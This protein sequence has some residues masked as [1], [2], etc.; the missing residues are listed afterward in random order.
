MG[1]SKRAMQ[2]KAPRG[3]AVEWVRPVKERCRAAAI[4][5]QHFVVVRILRARVRPHPIVTVRRPMARPAVPSCHGDYRRD[6]TE[7]GTYAKGGEERDGANHSTLPAKLDVINDLQGGS[8]LAL[9]IVRWCAELRAGH[10][11][12]TNRRY[13]FQV[14]DFTGAP[15]GNRTRVTAVR[16][17]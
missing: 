4:V 14:I 12:D 15:Y 6:A 13:A 2:R 7:R 9:P 17:T 5:Y 8:F 16:E 10:S 11:R 1:S 3:G